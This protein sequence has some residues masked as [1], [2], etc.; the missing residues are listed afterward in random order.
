M[1]FYRLSIYA[2]YLFI[3]FASLF[4]TKAKRWVDGR[5]NQEKLFEKKLP[6][7]KRVWFH[8]ASLG[9]FEQGRSLIHYFE[10]HKSEY[11]IVISFFSPSGY[12][13][14]KNYPVEGVYYLPLDTKKNA[15]KFIDFINP[16]IAIFN[17]YEYWHYMM[18]ELHCR[19]IPLF[20]TSAIFRKNQ[21]FF[22]WYG[23]FYRK[24]LGYVTHFFTQNQKSDA[25]LESIDHE[26]YTMAGDTRFDRV[27]E[28]SLNVK[29]DEK[30]SR[31][32][33]AKKCFVGGSTWMPDE[34]IILPLIEV[35]L[36]Y[37]FILVPHEINVEKI[38]A[39]KNKIGT[40]AFLY[41][42]FDAE[43]S[44]DKRVLIVDTIGLLSSIYNSSSISYI[45]GGFGKGIH[46]T[47]EAATF[48]KPIIFGPKYEKFQE[49]KDLIER[50]AAF[51]V[52]NADELQNIALKL[53]TDEE[54][55]S[56]ASTSA[57]EYVLEKKGATEIIM[58]Y[59][60]KCNYI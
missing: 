15:S 2:Y 33:D 41:S 18:K 19:E 47:L 11:S 56:R 44:S 46:N 10:K 24:T 28:H 17:K 48:A 39:L 30:I 37:K 5:K 12:E 51:S 29:D 38:H 45:G 14:R 49:A 13:Q 22:Q 26:N 42:E 55:Y 4:N 27:F 16:S 9:E 31:F 54:F 52:N 59:L 43:Y 25:L 23:W 40:I 60:Q 21:I 20:V 36:G 34:E 50:T 3:R 1:L 32:V 57:R 58:N 8:F 53:S 6:V 35:L 7:A